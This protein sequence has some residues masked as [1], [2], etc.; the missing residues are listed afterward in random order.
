ML[1]YCPNGNL[2]EYLCEVEK[3]E[4]D[5]ARTLIAQIIL[6]VEYLH[7][8]DI[9]YRDLKPE[10]IL[11][12]GHGYLKLAD[13]G[14]S[15]MTDRFMEARTFCGTPAYTCPDLL[16]GDPFT[17]A[18]D[19]YGIGCILYEMVMGDIPFFC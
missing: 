1:D 9:L 5:A 11:I 7:H 14:M 4:E 16:F 19:I 12:S 2:A 10:N 3:L 18:S 17:A 8:N 13:F 6:A 15:K